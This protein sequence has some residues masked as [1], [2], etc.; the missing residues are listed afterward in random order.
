MSRR[1]RE[2][3]VAVLTCAGLG[4]P[5]AGAPSGYGLSEPLGADGGVGALA[6]TPDGTLYLHEPPAQFGGSVDYLRVI[7]PDGTR[8]LLPLSG[9]SL[10]SVGGM[11]MAPGGTLL[12]TDQQGWGD[13]LGELYAVDVATGAGQTL[14]SG[15]DDIDD[16]AVRPGGEIFI[17]DAAGGGAGTV[18]H[19][20]YDGGTGAWSAVP[21]VTG[22]DYAAGVAF[23]PAGNLIYQ[24][25]TASFVGEVY[26]LR[27]QQAEGGLVFA[28]PELLATGLSAG[29][30]LAVDS[31][32]DVFVTGSGGLF[33]LDRD[34][35][36]GF[37]G[38]ASLFD[39]NGN[40]WQFGTEVAF[41]GGADPFE[42]WAGPD[43]GHLTYVPE[44]NSPTLR[45]VTPL[46]E[47]A[48][49]SLLTLAGSGV[50]LRR[51]RRSAE[52]IRK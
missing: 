38:T 44:F 11:A 46:P 50:V 12:V 28:V 33:E 41:L 52:R 51:G 42:S 35:G 43:G 8:Q 45:D 3:L 37:T 40:T 17:T 26:R 19:V 21:V 20:R 6:Y 47:P 4:L 15:I 30:D 13:G 27:I 31:E 10:S 1:A 24:Q 23:D 34:G 36:G 48:A 29:F 39:S 22:L 2:L 18:L 14:V 32:G 9:I 16:V 49:L 5:A 7:L 25:A